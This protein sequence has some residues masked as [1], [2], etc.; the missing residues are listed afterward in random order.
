MKINTIKEKL[1]N[2]TE[3]FASKTGDYAL[4]TKRTM[5]IKTFETKISSL[6]EKLGKSVYEK[7]NDNAESVPSDA[8]TQDLIQKIRDYKDRIA[9][10][11]EEI[12]HIRHKAEESRKEKKNESANTDT[13]QSSPGDESQEEKKETPEEN[14]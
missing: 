3:N 6:Y 13:Q 4:I 10:T 1:F 9:K 14:Q 2:F 12:S 11:Q 5:E 8:E 7:I